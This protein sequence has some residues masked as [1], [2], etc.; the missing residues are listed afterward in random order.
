MEGVTIFTEVEL[1]QGYLQISMA[2]ESRPM[3]AFQTPDDR[4]YHAS[5]NVSPRV[6]VCPESIFMRS[7]TT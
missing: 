1:S 2:E 6:L 7:Y 5:S 4:P 3:T